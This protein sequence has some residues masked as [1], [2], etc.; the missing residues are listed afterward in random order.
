MK[1][2][3]MFIV[4]ASL[5]ISNMALAITDPAENSL[6]VYFD[7]GTFDI[8]CI[9]IAPNQSFNMFFVIANCE[10]EYLGGFEFGWAFD[11]DPAGQYF[12][13]SA[14]FPTAALNLGDNQNL[15]VGY[16]VP[17]PTAEATVLVQFVILPLNTFT[18]D[19]TVGPAVPSS[20]D[21]R[22]VFVDGDV[23]TL[24]PM[25]FATVDGNTVIVDPDGWVRPG[26]GSIPCFGPVATEKS[27]WGSVKSLFN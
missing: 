6:G 26:I 5:A 11:P 18:T 23:T 21:G 27:S 1:K 9:D 13:L 10:F 8:N 16:S 15:L 17:V 12:I 22:A 19:I 2:R 24:L 7:E 3:L 14:T 20:I 25:N 4:L